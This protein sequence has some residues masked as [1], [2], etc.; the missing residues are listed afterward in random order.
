MRQKWLSVLLFAL[1]LAI[2]AF[3]PAAAD[4]ALAST[5]G[6]TR[7]SLQICLQS[8]GSAGTDELPGPYQSRHDPCLLCQVGSGGLTPLEAGPNP[9]GLAPVQWTAL[10]PWTVADRALPALRPNSS[11]QPRAPPANS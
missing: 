8:G 6:E 3:A 2:Q 9:V 4:I 10:L 7:A 5:S 11:H 1:A